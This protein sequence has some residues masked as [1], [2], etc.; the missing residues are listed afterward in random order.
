M[1]KRLTPK[2]AGKSAIEIIPELVRILT[3]MPPEE[4]EKAISAA[5][6]LLTGSNNG[7][8]EKPMD[9]RAAGATATD[10]L[11]ARAITWLKQHGL[12]REHIDQIFALDGTFDVIAARMPGRSKRQQTIEA[13]T[14]CGL[15]A[16]L[17]SGEPTFTDRDARLLCQRVGCYDPANHYN[18]MKGFDNRIT[19]SKESGWRLTN[20]GLTAAAQIV[21]ELAEGAH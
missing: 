15:R 8:Q 3:K 10:G 4:R 12:T 14:V 18:Y 6:I 1:K 16:F 13:Y 7:D 5:R 9:E 19:G 20:P 17:Q 11:S 21:S 2:S